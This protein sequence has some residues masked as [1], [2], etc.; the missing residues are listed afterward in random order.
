LVSGLK[1]RLKCLRTL[2]KAGFEK[3]KSTG[4]DHHGFGRMD[5]F[6]YNIVK[7]NSGFE[8]W[9]MISL[10]RPAKYQQLPLGGLLSCSGREFSGPHV[11]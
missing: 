2:N 3:S 10:K 9:Q 7:K 6:A 1:G 8:G 4:G 5:N 11:Y